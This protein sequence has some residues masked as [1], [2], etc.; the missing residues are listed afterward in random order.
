MAGNE[1]DAVSG[2]NFGFKINF[3]DFTTSK[4]ATLG[5]ND[6]KNAKEFTI[7]LNAA[8]IG[9]NSYLRGTNTVPMIEQR[10]VT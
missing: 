3:D 8:C 2:R 9:N 7:A 4:G 10:E 1:V 5:Q 6:D